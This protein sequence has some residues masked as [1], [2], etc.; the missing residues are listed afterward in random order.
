MA[1]T[2]RI[3]NNA[4]CMRNNVV[5]LSVLAKIALGGYDMR[6]FMPA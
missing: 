4:I 3:R 5:R 6:G 2:S 1:I